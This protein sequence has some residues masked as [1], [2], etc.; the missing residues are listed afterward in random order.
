VASTVKMSPTSLETTCCCPACAGLAS[1]ERPRFFTG[2][3]LTEAELNA[4]QAYVVEKNRL[5]N[6]YLHGWGIVCGLRVSCLGDECVNVEAGYALDPCGNDIVIPAD[7]AIN[8]IELIRGC[9]DKERER[10]ECDPLILVDSSGCRD[11]EEE[12]C[13]TIAYDERE[14]RPVAALRSRPAFACS[15]GGHGHANGNGNGVSNGCTCRGAKD[16]YTTATAPSQQTAVAA[17][18][19]VCEP[20][21]RFEGFRFGVVRK[22]DPKWDLPRDRGPMRSRLPTG[23]AGPVA[24]DTWRVALQ[25]CAEGLVELY[26]NAPSPDPEDVQKTYRECCEYQRR[27][28]AFI[29][30]RP[31]VFCQRHRATGENGCRAPM[32]GEEPNDYAG[33]IGN[34]IGALRETLMTVIRECQCWTL[35][36]PCPAPP[37]EERLVLACVTVQGDKVLRICPGEE[38]R[39]LITFPALAY[40]IPGLLGTALASYLPFFISPV[41]LGRL[42][43]MLCCGKGYER[44]LEEDT[45]AGPSLETLLSALR[46]ADEETERLREEVDKLRVEVADLAARTG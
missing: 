26:E 29:A 14:S 24:A 34:V 8:V 41:T 35:L 44:R 1:F 43:E 21:R 3:L 7:Q 23:R 19:A 9:K 33:E 30:T 18:A 10:D 22:P 13:I 42:I 38:R 37:C 15:C 25:E 5:H 45:E 2:Q 11:V 40:W 32:E 12:W 16:G 39:Q 31:T 36:T 17:R 28:K 27:I 6:R 20:T 4:E 46:P